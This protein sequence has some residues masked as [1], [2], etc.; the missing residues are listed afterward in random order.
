ME[1]IRT[2]EELKELLNEQI[3][4]IRASCKAYDAGNIAEAKRLS[5]ALRILLYD[6]KGRTKSV[7]SQMGVKGNLSFFAADQDYNWDDVVQHHNIKTILNQSG[8]KYIAY[9]NRKEHPYATIL[10]FDK[11]WNGL[12]I[13]GDNKSLTRGDIIRAVADTDGGAH[14]DSSISGIYAEI[15]KNNIGIGYVTDFGPN[16][17]PEFE[18]LREALTQKPHGFELPS[19][20]NEKLGLSPNA[21]SQPAEG[22]LGLIFIR[23]IA[24]EVL[25]TFEC[26]VAKLGLTWPEGESVLNPST[27][28]DDSL[29]DTEPYLLMMGTTIIKEPTPEGHPQNF[30]LIMTAK[31]SSAKGNTPV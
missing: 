24:Y 28:E 21:I 12:L 1:H 15:I 14:I 10:S 29:K 6:G 16:P 2:Q 4:F 8:V 19:E 30:S 18:K 13:K 5:V 22:K 31:S 17:S 26:E 7:L 9:T 23:Q 27:T 25:A 20:A 11:W 3:E